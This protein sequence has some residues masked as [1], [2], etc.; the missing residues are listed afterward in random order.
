MHML[1]EVTWKLGEQMGLR[2]SS[3]GARGQVTRFFQP[4]LNRGAQTWNGWA[5][6]FMFGSKQGCRRGASG[7]G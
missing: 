4:S 1:A 5:R 2:C 6:E 7:H 3:E